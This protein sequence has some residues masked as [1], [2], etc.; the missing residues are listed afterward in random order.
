MLDFGKEQRRYHIFAKHLHPVGFAHNMRPKSVETLFRSI[1]FINIRNAKVLEVGCGQGYLVNH[2]L[3]AKAKHVIGTEINQQILDTIPM[4]AFSIYSPKQTVQFKIETFED[5]DPNMRVDIVSIFIGNLR[6]IK[7][8]IEMFENNRY[9]KIL[10]FMV[11]VRE[12][13]PTRMHLDVLCEKNNW[14]LIEF[15]IHLSVSGEQRRTIVLKKYVPVIDLSN[16]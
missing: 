11:P 12:F 4:G 3:F 8:G 14:S 16:V 5:T 1:G 6:I 13:K 15:P 9:V 2:F 10:A 7:K